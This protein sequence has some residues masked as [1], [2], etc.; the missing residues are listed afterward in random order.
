M[1][2]KSRIH[3]SLAL[4]TKQEHWEPL[5][6]APSTTCAQLYLLIVLLTKN[7]DD[8]SS[9]ESV[10]RPPFHWDLCRESTKVRQTSRI[11][12]VIKGSGCLTNQPHTSIA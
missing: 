1:K 4:G 7:M 6:F 11:S 9:S 5:A 3:I 12:L 8:L 10:S 2:N